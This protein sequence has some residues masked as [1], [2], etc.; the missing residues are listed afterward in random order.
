MHISI[1]ISFIISLVCRHASQQERG[2]WANTS[3]NTHTLPD[4]L[5]RMTSATRQALQ[6][7]NDNSDLVITVT[8]YEFKCGLQATD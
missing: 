1:L 6:V 5:E 8:K 4:A 7:N 2:G 3:P